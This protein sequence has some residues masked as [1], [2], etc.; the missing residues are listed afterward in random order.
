VNVIADLIARRAQHTRE[1]QALAHFERLLPA[2]VAQRGGEP[3]AKR[4]KP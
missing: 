2:I 4:A 1:V 3:A